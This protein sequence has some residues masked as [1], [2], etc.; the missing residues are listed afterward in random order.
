MNCKVILKSQSDNFSEQVKSSGRITEEN[1]RVTVDYAID[2]DKCRIVISKEGV[3]QRREGS[4]CVSVRF[5]EGRETVCTVGTEGLSGSYKIFTERIE[6]SR[7]RGGLGL[8]LCYL[9]GEEG[10]RITINLGVI[11]AREQELKK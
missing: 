9:S 11:I 8:K 5:V 3:I 1:G 7:K 4:V 2:G 6:Y 10:E